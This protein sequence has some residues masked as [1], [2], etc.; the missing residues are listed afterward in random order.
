MECE[1]LGNR[2][3]DRETRAPGQYANSPA[4]FNY[5]SLTLFDVLGVEYHGKYK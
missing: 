2:T 1:Y 3:V 5:L 4:I